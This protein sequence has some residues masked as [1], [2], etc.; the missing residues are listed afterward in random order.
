MDIFL[1]VFNV[2]GEGISW[3]CCTRNWGLTWFNQGQMI[4]LYNGD[5]SGYLTRI[6][7]GYNQKNMIWACLKIWYE[8]RNLCQVEAG[9]QAINRAGLMAIKPITCRDISWKI[10]NHIY[11]IC[12]D[13]F[14]LNH[15]KGNNILVPQH[16]KGFRF[17]LSRDLSL[18]KIDA[19]MP[20]G[21]TVQ[22]WL[23]YLYEDCNDCYIMLYL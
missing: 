23:F 1:E 12:W 9:N 3:L 13:W 15:F 6:S 19:N 21:H 11:H 2:S 7:R 5:N 10:N 16:R 4:E 18:K 17:E 20:R 22:P 8:P 14:G